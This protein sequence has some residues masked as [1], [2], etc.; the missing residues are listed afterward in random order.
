MDLSDMDLRMSLNILLFLD[1]MVVELWLMVEC[2]NNI[3]IEL[4]GYYKL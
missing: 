2:V 4:G 1:W 3:C